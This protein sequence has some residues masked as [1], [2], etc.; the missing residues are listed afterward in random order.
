MISTYKFPVGLKT[1]HMKLVLFLNKL[2]IE[3]VF[4]LGCKK[5]IR[6]KKT[7]MCPGG[8]QYQPLFKLKK[9]LPADCVSFFLC[10]ST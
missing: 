2:S 5:F 9:D 1:L 3:T 10:F 6:E 7:S 4:H 8:K